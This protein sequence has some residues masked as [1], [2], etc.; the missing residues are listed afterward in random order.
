M[1]TLSAP[2][3]QQAV[4]LLAYPGSNRSP[5]GAVHVVLPIPARHRWLLRGSP[6]SAK[7]MAH[8]PHRESTEVC[9]DVG[10]EET[11]HDGR[12]Q[13]CAHG[14]ASLPRPASLCRPSRHDI[15]QPVKGMPL[16]PHRV[17]T[18]F[19]SRCKLVQASLD[20]IVPSQF[21]TFPLHA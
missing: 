7:D 1:Q 11:S 5:I 8:G 3:G 17:E 12:V 4:H 21:F 15:G 6:L 20:E 9:V 19:T 14:L 18:A 10:E 2:G 13:M 16:R